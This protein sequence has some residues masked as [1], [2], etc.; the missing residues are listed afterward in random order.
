MKKLVKDSE[1]NQAHKEH[2]AFMNLGVGTVIYGLAFGSIA[3]D[4]PQFY[5]VLSLPVF[6]GILLFAAKRMPSPLQILRELQ[7]EKDGEQVTEEIRDLEKDLGWK[8]VL[9]TYA[10]FTYSIIIYLVVLIY[11]ESILTI[12]SSF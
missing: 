1:W 10:V 2:V 9:T 12:S 5:A 6:I 7:K 3:T 11:P 4:K 8:A